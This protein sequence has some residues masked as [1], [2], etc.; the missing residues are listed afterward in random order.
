M[1]M[2]GVAKDLTGLANGCNLLGRGPEVLNGQRWKGIGVVGGVLAVA[3][4]RSLHFGIGGQAPG[5]AR[6]LREFRRKLM[7][8]LPIEAKG[9]SLAEPILNGLSCCAPKPPQSRP[10]VSNN[11]V[12][13]E[14][15]LPE[16]AGFEKGVTL[17]SISGVSAA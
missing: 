2:T 11:V 15:E 7:R 16:F 3:L 4:P 9:V 17:G 14:H 5:L 6:G 13:F 12:V 1:T 10:T 8:L